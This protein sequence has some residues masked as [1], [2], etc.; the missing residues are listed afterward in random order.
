[1]KNTIL[2]YGRFGIISALACYLVIWYSDIKLLAYQGREIIGFVSIFIATSFVF[3]GIK[4]FRDAVNK[5]TLGFLQGIKIGFLITVF[6]AVTFGIFTWAYIKYLN[7]AYAKITYNQM[8]EKAKQLYSGNELTV[9]LT[10][11]ES[12]RDLLG[13]ALVQ[14]G[15]MLVT[16]LCIGTIISVISSLFLKRI[17]G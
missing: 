8:V 6:P 13:N 4:Y 3:L 5:G 2:R 12:K 1:M 17:P 10:D 7:P 9:Y 11:L 16:V 14:A 15:I